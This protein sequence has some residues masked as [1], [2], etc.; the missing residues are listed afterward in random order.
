MYYHSETYNGV[1][2]LLREPHTDKKDQNLP[3]EEI[4]NKSNEWVCKMLNGSSYNSNWK[5]TDKAMA[6]LYR[7]RLGQ[8][9]KI[10]G[11]NPKELPNIGYDNLYKPGGGATKSPEYGKNLKEYT[12]SAFEQLLEKLGYQ[13]RYIFTCC[14]TYNQLKCVQPVTEEAE[15]LQYKTFNRTCKQF[16]YRDALGNDVRIFAIYHPSSRTTLKENQHL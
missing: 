2:F 14:D 10:I 11:I 3:V 9:L 12:R 6:T 5:R 1:L 4:I 15:G 8:I 13:T 16:L 7:K